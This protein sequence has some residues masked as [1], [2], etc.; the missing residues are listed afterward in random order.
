M[1][2]RLIILIVLAILFTTG[3]HS[4]GETIG[5]RAT[6][7]TDKKATATVVG[8]G[9]S[10]SPSSTVAPSKEDTNP[11]TY[12]TDETEET[13]DTVGTGEGTTA[14]T[15]ESDKLNTSGP[16]TDKTDNTSKLVSSG[17][18]LKTTANTTLKT[19]VKTTA[20]TTGKTTTPSISDGQLLSYWVNFPEKGTVKTTQAYSFTVKTVENGVSV[21]AY[22]KDG[23]Q[24][25]TASV[26]LISTW[27]YSYEITDAKGGTVTK[28]S[29][30]AYLS[31]FTM[32]ILTSGACSSNKKTVT[33][34]GYYKD[35]EK[36]NAVVA[37]QDLNSSF[38]IARGSGTWTYSSFYSTYPSSIMKVSDSTSKQS[39]AINIKKGNTLYIDEFSQSHFIYTPNYTIDNG[40][41]TLLITI[42]NESEYN[43][44]LTS[45]DRKIKEIWSGGR[46]AMVEGSTKAYN[47]K[48]QQGLLQIKRRGQS[49][50]D[51]PKKPFT[52]EL[53][54]QQTLTN[55]T[56]NKDWILVANY[57][58]K[59]LLRNWFAYTTGRAMGSMYVPDCRTIDVYMGKGSTSTHLGTY[60]LVEKLEVANNKMNIKEMTAEDKSIN[61]VTTSSSD[62]QILAG[63]F[64]VEIE[65]SD[66]FGASDVAVKSEC[67]GGDRYL[68]IKSPDKDLFS[69]V[70]NFAT[71]NTNLTN[72]IR[73]FFTVMDTYVNNANSSTNKTNPDRIFD[74]IDI[75]SFVDYYIINELAKNVDG[76]FVL[77]TYFYKDKG[78]KLYV[79]IWD[80][81][82]AYGNCNY[83]SDSNGNNCGVY[84]GHYIGTNTTWYRR[85]LR[86]DKF[87][88][89]VKTRW[90]ALRKSG[91]IY[92]DASITNLFT[93]E[94]A[95]IKASAAANFATW[96]IL[97][98]QV[99][100]NPSEMVNNNK[101]YDSN[102][103][104]TINWIKNRA[105]W[106]DTNMPP[107]T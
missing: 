60:L 80:F 42:D 23:S 11:E 15:N 33:F 50:F 32:N 107:V 13:G 20:K 30:K 22:N 46:Y 48:S 4:D 7:P 74:F 102:I 66:R 59:T 55:M 94:S 104:Y 93:Q 38:E 84:T 62:T 63:S 86:N 49:S 52:I 3:C 100:P 69:P 68:N 82:I 10:E 88:N 21:T 5:D 53:S 96:P 77:S 64:L 79:T 89:A 78:G 29:S 43:T 45:S 34:T 90:T 97:G 28:A 85:L 76:G 58:D 12:I 70:N 101:T 16:N 51:M 47:T 2:K 35:F 54:E 105:A 98:T 6:S 25:K 27:L 9:I 65:S 18:T 44:L 8:N 73:T 91:G 36:S 81:D 83:A 92:S 19:T 67:F 56:A 37:Y 26:S 1:K 103:T 24:N 41:P 99:W 75:N 106:L 72:Y 61:T 57:S 31:T 95:K 14:I 71:K 17:S 40:V 39:I 87:R